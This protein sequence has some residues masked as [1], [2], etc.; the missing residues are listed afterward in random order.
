ME[1]FSNMRNT[2]YNLF[3]FLTECVIGWI[4][5]KGARDMC[6]W[7]S[8]WLLQ[9]MHAASHMFNKNVEIST[10]FS[11]PFTI[12]VIDIRK[13]DK[14]PDL[15]R[16]KNVHSERSN[17]CKWQAS[18]SL[19][20]NAGYICCWFRW[21]LYCRLL[22]LKTCEGM[23]RILKTHLPLWVNLDYTSRIYHLKRRPLDPGKHGLGMQSLSLHTRVW[24][25]GS[26]QFGRRESDTVLYLHIPRAPLAR[27]NLMMC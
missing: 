22:E 12:T 20:R 8:W 21:H 19:R 27:G 16:K 5:Y 18:I 15:W 26:K 25:S 11:R 24:F 14:V 6:N 9:C 1:H 10:F 13:S 3:F 4:R 17:S 7:L 2:A 23:T